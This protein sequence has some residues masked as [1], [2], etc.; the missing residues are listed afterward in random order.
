MESIQFP[1]DTEVLFQRF[2]KSHRFPSNDFEKQAILIHL[3]EDFK[4][5]VVYT[6]EEVSQIIEKYFSDST[7]IRREFINFGYMQRDPYKGTYWV[8]KRTLTEEDI[9]KNTFLRAHAKPFKVL[10]EDQ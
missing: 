8:M 9:R 2:C 1:F 6:E 5:A 7:L 4:D 3:L 10:K